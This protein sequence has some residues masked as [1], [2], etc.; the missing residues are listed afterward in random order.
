MQNLNFLNNLEAE[1][2]I[3]GLIETLKNTSKPII[4]FP[5]G[6]VAK[7]IHNTLQRYGVTISLFG[8][9]NVSKI[10]TSI[11]GKDVVS[12]SQITKEYSDA[13][14]LV[15][16]KLYKDEIITQFKAAG[17]DDS[18]LIFKIFSYF[19]LIT[20]SSFYKEMTTQ[21]NNL[22]TLINLLSD[23]FSRE[24]L[25]TKLQ[26]MYDFDSSNLEKVVSKNTMYFDE[27][28][29][30]IKDDEVF[31]DGGSFTG[32]TFEA[33][34]EKTKNWSHYYAFEPDSDNFITLNENVSLYNNVTAIQKGLWSNSDTLYFNSQDGGSSI[35]SDTS[36][37]TT[38]IDVVSIDEYFKEMAVSFIKLD[39]EG[40]ERETLEGAVETI[41]KHKPILAVCIYHKPMDIIE[42][43]LF[44]HSLCPD[45]KMYIRHYGIDGTDTV[46][47]L[48][49]N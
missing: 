29:I 28:I 33:F 48:I 8:D 27:D 1:N 39:V 3:L 46:C 26:F 34:L 18:Q 45:S 2:N 9:N 10:G 38:S 17:F 21:E 6:T 13:Y 43:P 23:E 7:G 11:Y 14:I 24:T 36:N 16:S 42:L 30:K 44:M 35:V 20:T 12:F 37:C 49:P 32:D 31:V 19:E 41:K 22:N 47:Y 4:C 15:S 5:A 40:S 25:L